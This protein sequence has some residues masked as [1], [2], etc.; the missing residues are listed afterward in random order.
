[1]TAP[2][3][4]CNMALGEIGT[5]TL[6][7][8]LV[9]D[10][11]AARQC[12]LFY[13]ITRQQLLRAAPWG[14]ARRT[15]T[16][17]QLALAT[18][19]PNIVPYPWLAMYAYPSDAL[20]MRYVLPPPVLPPSGD[21]PDV[22]STLVVPW[23]PPRRDWRYLV[24]ND[25]STDPSRKVLLT[26]VPYALGVYTADI[27]DPDL[28][29]S[30]FIQALVQALAYKLVMPLTGNAGM[31]SGY[32]QLAEQALRD[33]RAVDGNESIPT[34]DHTVDWIAT[35]EVGAWGN[36]P[37]WGGGVNWLTQG[38]WFWG[39]DSMSWSM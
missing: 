30:L 22:S 11:T 34:T 1:M 17:T 33:A 7:A 21:A 31:K 6:I 37:G 25:T 15:V 18:D 19:D 24:S 38:S 9:D 35:R 4:I 3:D 12:N 36:W 28:F 10:T 39:W 2:V 29:D 23:C 26:N 16:L 14:F 13:D 27:D 20:K 5:R 32:A 8:S